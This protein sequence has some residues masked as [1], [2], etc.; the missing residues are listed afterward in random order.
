MKLRSLV[1]GLVSCVLIGVPAA[2]YA[3]PADPPTSA[4]TDASASTQS[5]ASTTA[6]AENSAES[7]T[8]SGDPAETTASVP[9][10]AP[11]SASASVAE[12]QAA[13]SADIVWAEVTTSPTLR[14]LTAG[15]TATITVTIFGERWSG[16]PGKLPA[17]LTVS[18][19]LSEDG[20]GGVQQPLTCAP[21]PSRPA[22]T[23]IVCTTSY[24]PVAERT[25]TY[26]TEF[27][28]L[29]SSDAPSGGA[30]E[31]AQFTVIPSTALTV[32]KTAG[33]S[34]TDAEG[35]VTVPYEVTIANTGPKVESLDIYDQLTASASMRFVDFTVSVLE[36]PA[37]GVNTAPSP[38]SSL[39]EGRLQYARYSLGTLDL[40]PGETL[41]LA[42]DVRYVGSPPSDTLT[43][44]GALGHG[45][46]NT[47]AT[48]A[49]V[50]PEGAGVGTE[51]ATY[52]SAPGYLASACADTPSAGLTLSKEVVDAGP[53]QAGETAT[54]S[55]T[56]K[57]TLA[58]EGT[59]LGEVWD[60][61]ERP[62]AGMGS[63]TDKVTW[64]ATVD[65]EVYREFEPGGV[66]VA[67]SE[68]DLSNSD[69]YSPIAPYLALAPGSTVTW[70]V[71]VDY[72]HYFTDGSTCS[73]GSDAGLLNTISARTSIDSNNDPTYAPLFRDL[74]AAACADLEGA[75]T[76][77]KTPGTVEV[78]GS[79][80]IGTASYEVVLRNPSDLL[81][82]QVYAVTDQPVLPAGVEM[83]ELS[84]QGTT[85]GGAELAWVPEEEQAAALTG[86][87]SETGGEPVRLHNSGPLFLPPGASVTWAVKV[88]FQVTA[89]AADALCTGEP[90]HGLYN[91]AALPVA[92]PLPSFATS[93]S[94]RTPG[95]HRAEFACLDLPTP[96]L[97]LAQ[98]A[99]LLDANGDQVG[100]P[101]ERVVFHFAVRN[102]GRFNLDQ[103]AITDQ[104]VAQ[105]GLQVTC[106]ADTLPAGAS[107]EC[108][109]EEY[110]IT[111]A[112]AAAGSIV[113]TAT[114]RALAA[115]S[116]Q[117]VTADSTLTI[118]VTADVATPGDPT[119][120]PDPSSTPD[121]APSGS[122][123]AGSGT[124]SQ[125]S[126][127][128]S[129]GTT[130]GPATEVQFPKPPAAPPGLSATTRALPRTGVEGA[131]LLGLGVVLLLA[132]AATCLTGRRRRA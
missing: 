60:L 20:M 6:S 37:D 42:V 117:A 107:T 83:L 23:Q 116:R 52:P 119:S 49:G 63:Q 94:T 124:A 87:T 59:V 32:S 103:I 54:S 69:L 131:E 67:A 102:T 40:A 43:C 66:K 55:V 18:A 41:R 57:V 126:A 7:A 128:T 101:G 91:Q 114:V 90:G 77:A 24:T 73:D 122:S 104:F 38:V 132:G 105:A 111:D 82:A 71:V 44:D 75:P 17:D 80:G 96:A 85:S 84:W 81:H 95:T 53:V 36:G 33:A 100:N 2:S 70:T 130:Q 13:D 121:P 25:D 99:T 22:G 48:K 56:Y 110:V 35:V 120:E 46:V 88:R 26:Q 51:G 11:A 109:T 112:D 62:Y 31:Q 76:L 68:A 29:A 78:D 4:T 5:E 21:D 93:G 50:L 19:T 47:I 16:E 3:A 58:N 27:A 8:S 30:A 86:T 64:T 1:S 15:Q 65:G 45:L 89:P 123:G 98:T 108:R 28:V 113:N 106:D 127:S 79:T 14:V 129:P 9:A 72:S 61:I 10:D 92:A 34:T 115:G 74:S 118:P 39:Q 97:E 125:P 12:A